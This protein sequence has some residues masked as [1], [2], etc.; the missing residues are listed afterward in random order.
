MRANTNN[1]RTWHLLLGEKAGMRASYPCANGA[2]FLIPSKE[3]Y[4]APQK[5][6]PEN[7]L[8]SSNFQR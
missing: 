4:P 5:I 1:R 3:F 7:S 8:C 2:H 6:F